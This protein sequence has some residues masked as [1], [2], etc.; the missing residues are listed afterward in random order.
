ML[1]DSSP[2]TEAAM[3]WVEETYAWPDDDE[4]LCLRG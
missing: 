4:T 3:A 1:V 2:E